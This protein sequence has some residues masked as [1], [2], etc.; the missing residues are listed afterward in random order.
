MDI[1]VAHTLSQQLVP[2]VVMELKGITVGGGFSGISGE[3]STF[4]H[5][6]FSSTVSAIE[7]VL[8]DGTLKLAS[9]HENEDLLRGAA[10]TMGT[11]GVVVLLTVELME[12][13][14]FV[15]LELLRAPVLNDIPDMLESATKRE[16]DFIDSISFDDRSAVIMV[17]KMSQ[18]ATGTVDLKTGLPSNAWQKILR[19][20][21]WRLG[22][23]RLT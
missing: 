8:G 9:R 18:R 7:I 10:G 12:A 13:K 1:L 3:S 16:V 21:S 19:S 23:V 14:K 20:K 17:G 15:N 6:L 2:K 5:G 11:L 4:K 22:G